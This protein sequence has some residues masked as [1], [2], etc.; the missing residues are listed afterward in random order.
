V[1]GAVDGRYAPRPDD[2]ARIEREELFEHIKG[3][4]FKE[5]LKY[6]QDTKA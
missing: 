3:K 5:E 4:R 6:Q 1:K 2:L